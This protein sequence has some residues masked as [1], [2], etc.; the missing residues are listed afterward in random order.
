MHELLNKKP[1]MAVLINSGAIK[2]AKEKY[3]YKAIFRD[4]VPVTDEGGI[5]RPPVR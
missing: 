4:S 5:F 1:S 2:T 3:N